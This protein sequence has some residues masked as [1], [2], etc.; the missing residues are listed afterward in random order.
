MSMRIL[1]GPILHKT[2]LV[3]LGVGFIIS[4]ADATT[5]NPMILAMLTANA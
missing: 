1:I 5:E 4:L 2:I 3:N